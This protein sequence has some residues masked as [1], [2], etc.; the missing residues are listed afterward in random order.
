MENF[1]DIRTLALVTGVISIALSIGMVYLYSSHKTYSGFS[2]WTIG[3]I[4]AGIGAILLCLRGNAPDLLTIPLANTLIVAFFC[5]VSWGMEMF[6]ETKISRGPDYAILFVFV[7]TFILFT[8]IFPNVEIRIVAVCFVY[9][10]FCL[11]ASWILRHQKVSSRS[12]F[13][14]IILMLTAGW[15][16]LRSIITIIEPWGM[17]DFMRAGTFHSLAFIVFIVSQ[18]LVTIGLIFAN[19]HK[20][21]AE[22][23]DSNKA[24]INSEE[25][26]RSLSEASFE[27]IVIFDELNIIEANKTIGKMLG[28][29]PS[30]LIGI[31]AINFVA[32]D[33]RE[34]LKNKILSGEEKPYESI[35]L[36]KDGTTF[37]VEVHARMFP[38]KGQQVRVSA[39]RDISEQKKVEAEIKTLRGILPI[40]A[41]CKKIRDNKGYW[42]QVEA[43]IEHYSEVQFSHGMCEECEE[44]FYGEEKW[45]KKLKKCDDK[46]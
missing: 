25:R 28:Y 27:G 30:E 6:T 21:E 40:C 29:K 23:I 11:K 39:V 43:Y 20:L 31:E 46:K 1:P 4:C 9:A 14:Q 45:Y 2:L 37:P 34:K 12:F 35:C 8:F 24:L 36:R 3:S 18:I 38:Y 22:L 33:E 42:N 16:L 26:F 7:S 5:C 32:P 44:K 19:H 41:S 17:N 10:F 13:L 15:Y